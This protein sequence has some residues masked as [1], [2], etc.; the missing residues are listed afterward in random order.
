MCF[1][2][3]HN[4]VW[5][6]SSILPFIVLPHMDIMASTIIP[7][8]VTLCKHL[9]AHEALIADYI[10]KAP[11]IININGLYGAINQVIRKPN[12]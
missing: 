5:S 10:M 1:H 11:S 8:T 9:H 3:D 7:Y 12:M 6:G 4:M 2:L